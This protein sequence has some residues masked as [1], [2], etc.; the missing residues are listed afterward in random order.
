M[1]TTILKILLFTAIFCNSQN[2]FRSTNV[3]LITTEPVEKTFQ[4]QD[5]YLYAQ[6]ELVKDDN[7]NQIR[8]YRVRTDLAVYENFNEYQYDNVT[9]EILLDTN[10][11]P[12]VVVKQRLTW[13][14]TKQDW[15]TLEITYSEVDAFASSIA[16]II[17]AGLT[18][19]QQEMFE[20]NTIFLLQRQQQQ[21]WGIDPNKWRIATPSDILP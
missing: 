16:N 15:Y 1:K 6:I 10:G 21:P 12:L 2:T 4:N 8:V 3:A 17:P 5:A 13:L 18:K 11:T 14:E 19:T 9:G 20:L 7:H